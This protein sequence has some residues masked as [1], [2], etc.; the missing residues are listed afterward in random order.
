MTAQPL[1]PAGRPLWSPDPVRQR[2]GNYTVEDVLALPDDAPRVELRDGVMI[3]VPSPT[4]GHQDISALLWMWLRQHAPLDLVPSVATGVLIDGVQTFEPDVLLLQ[5]ET[6]NPQSH[7]ALPDHVVLV[8]EVV[9]PS[10]RRRDRLE[11]PAG[12]AAAGIRYFWRIEQDPVRIYAYELVDGGYQ[13]VA[14]AAEE[15]VLEK[16]FEIRLPVRDIAG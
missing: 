1:G 3:V 2:L 7:Y 5:R 9:S 13:L 15:L 6:L 16:P 10:T 4:F 14:E 12:Y 11:K 8:V